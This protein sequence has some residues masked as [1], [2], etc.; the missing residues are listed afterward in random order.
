MDHVTLLYAGSE[1]EDLKT[2][3]IQIDAL[4]LD[5]EG[6][7]IRL[8]ARLLLWFNGGHLQVAADL[9][10]EAVLAEENQE[11]QVLATFRICSTQP[12]IPSGCLRVGWSG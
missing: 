8:P 5:L 4:R 3:L 11:L 10:G 6:Q 12:S 1:A 9:E 2:E 7:V